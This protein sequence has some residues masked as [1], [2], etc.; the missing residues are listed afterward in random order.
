MQVGLALYLALVL[1]NADLFVTTVSLS[2]L[3]FNWIIKPETR[4][5]H[6]PNLLHTVF[7]SVAKGANRTWTSFGIYLRI[8][9]KGAAEHISPVA[10]SALKSLKEDV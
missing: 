10:G 9:R 7:H 5:Q 1:A 8:W 3:Y 6:I 4:S 2:A